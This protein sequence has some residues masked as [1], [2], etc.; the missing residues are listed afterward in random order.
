MPEDTVKK[1]SFYE[2]RPVRRRLIDTMLSQ[3]TEPYDLV[4]L[5]TLRMDNRMLGA[6]RA[7]YSITAPQHPAR[8]CKY[9]DVR[10][11]EEDQVKAHRINCTKPHAVADYVFAAE[12]V[13]KRMTILRACPLCKERG[14][15]S[16]SPGAL[17]KHVWVKHVSP[18]QENGDS[19]CPF[20][21]C[22]HQVKTLDDVLVHLED[23]HC[24]YVANTAESVTSMDDVV[25]H[26]TK[27]CD[28]CNEFI[29][30]HA[31]WRRHCSEHRDE[32]AGT[33]SS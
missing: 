12:P 21:L 33:S 25:S 7:V 23:R 27:H 18:H 4:E 29:F 11:L 6:G 15:V 32:P 26:V 24:L 10:G 2:L 22:K 17:A 1:E 16:S 14:D 31:D 20:P 9:C 8:G 13:V 30:G 5:V 28:T 19:K 3:S